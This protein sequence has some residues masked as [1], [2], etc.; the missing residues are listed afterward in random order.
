MSVGEQ[1][2]YGQED[3]RQRSEPVERPEGQQLEAY[4]DLRDIGMR[5]FLC[6]RY[7]ACD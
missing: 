4:Q 7:P 2:R 5:V 1:L 3:L 6:V